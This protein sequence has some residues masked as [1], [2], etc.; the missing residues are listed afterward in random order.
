MAGYSAPNGGY[1]DQVVEFLKGWFTGAIKDAEPTLA[2]ACLTGV[3]RI[4]K[5]S[6]FSDLNNLS[7]S[8]PLSMDFD[9]RFGFI[10]NEVS[11]L[12]D[13]L[14]YSDCM[15]EAR[16]WYDGYRFGRQ[17]IYSPW[18]VLNYIK[19]GCSPRT[20]WAN[21][22]GNSVLGDMV[23]NADAATMEKLYQLCEP[24][25]AV[26]APL[27]I[28]ELCSLMRKRALTSSGACSTWRAT[29]KPTSPSMRAMGLAY[30]TSRAF[31]T[32]RL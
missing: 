28:L 1:Y 16:V 10:D 13:Y 8:T 6:I 23:A 15:S 17:S 32:A 2:F 5:E 18:S 11:A 4:S 26:L 9:E 21:T 22:S 27:L 30:R 19:Q 24:G 25:G 14:G 20:Y 31:L 7:V 29:L 3:Q 12:A